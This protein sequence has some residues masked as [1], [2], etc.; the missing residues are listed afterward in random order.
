MQ[1]QSTLY[2]EAPGCIIWAAGLDRC[3][4]CD[5]YRKRFFISVNYKSGSVLELLCQSGWNRNFASKGKG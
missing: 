4:S 1:T 3:G 5:M 2:S